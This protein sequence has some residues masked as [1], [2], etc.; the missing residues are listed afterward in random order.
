MVFLVIYY[1]YNGKELVIGDMEFSE[2][3]VFENETMG[4]AT[5]YP[6]KFSILPQDYPPES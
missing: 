3:F 6:K 2:D 5:A 4:I 1:D